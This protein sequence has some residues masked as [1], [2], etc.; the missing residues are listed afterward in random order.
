MQCVNGMYPLSYRL[1]LY[2]WDL[3]K[4]TVGPR[5]HV[6]SSYMS[7]WLVYTVSVAA[8]IAIDDT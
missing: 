7:P 8:I 1:K 2:G 3:E 6:A 5:G 4:I